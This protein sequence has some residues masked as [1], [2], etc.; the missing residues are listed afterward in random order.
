[1]QMVKTIASIH[2]LKRQ[3]LPFISILGDPCTGG[4]I[5]SYASLGDV[6]IA[7]PKAL[8]IFTG[9]RVMKSRGF[10]VDESLVRS[11]SLQQLSA[12]IY[13]HQ[14]YFFSIRGI[15]QITERR[16]MKREIVK[17]IEFYHKNHLKKV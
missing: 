7:E 9:P 11:D 4:A 1:M 13:K 5:A 8:V 3:G 17:Y 14:D 10:E 12:L 15:H 6:I 2:R 16:D